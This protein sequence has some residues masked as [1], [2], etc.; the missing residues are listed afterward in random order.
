MNQSEKLHHRREKIPMNDAQSLSES[1]PRGTIAISECEKPITGAAEN[2]GEVLSRLGDIPPRRV[3]LQPR[4]GTATEKDVVELADHFDR[5]CELIDG[6][7]V[8]KEMGFAEGVPATA[9]ISLLR[10]FVTARNLG[11]V[12]GADGMVELWPG[13]VR[14]PDVSFVSWSR[15]P[16]RRVPMEPVP[17]LA[18]DLAIEILSR[19]NTAAEMKLKRTDY[20]RSGVTVVWEVDPR[21]RL[22]HVHTAPDAK[23]TLSASDVLD[24]GD[25]L[26]GLTILVSAIFAELDRHG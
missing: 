26:P 21:S 12:A 14:I 13:R 25:A 5:R 6:I 10:E 23:T 20:F 1:E 11:I 19:G 9:I 17:K 18:P 8:E 24:G 7:L 16:G 2:L 3:R 15:L 22:I 4:F